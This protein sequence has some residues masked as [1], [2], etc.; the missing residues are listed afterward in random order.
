MKR[1]SVYYSE[2]F[3]SGGKKKQELVMK[4]LMECPEVVEVTY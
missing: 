2:W 4:K 3:T 1:S